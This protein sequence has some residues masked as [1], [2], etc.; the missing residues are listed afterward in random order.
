MVKQIR[1]NTMEFQS[2]GVW[3][4]ISRDRLIFDLNRSLEH[5][6]TIKKQPLPGADVV[7]NLLQKNPQVYIRTIKSLWQNGSVCFRRQCIQA[8]AWVKAAQPPT[9]V[10]VDVWMILISLNGKIVLETAPL[11]KQW[12]RQYLYKAHLSLLLLDVN[13]DRR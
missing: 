11:W 3:P 2:E 1:F 13:P 10:S 5:P 4:L 12:L 7:A 9:D 8:P 6:E